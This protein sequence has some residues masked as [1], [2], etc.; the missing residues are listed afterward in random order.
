MYALWVLLEEEIMGYC[1]RCDRKW[2]SLSECHC[3]GCCEHFRGIFAFDKHKTGKGDNI[4][5][6]TIEEMFEKGMVYD[7]LPRRWVSGRQPEGLNL[8]RPLKFKTIKRKTG[9]KVHV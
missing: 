9:I 4:R 6:L 5:C 2:K 8:H 3:S 7:E 1:P